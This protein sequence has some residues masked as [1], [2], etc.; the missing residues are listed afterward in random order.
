M[1][2]TKYKFA[3]ANTQYACYNVKDLKREKGRYFLFNW[4]MGKKKTAAQP[5]TGGKKICKAVHQYSS[6]KISRE[7]MDR[8]LDIAR[9]CM[10][11]CNYVYQKYGGIKSLDKIYPGYTVQNEMTTSSLREK[12]NLPTVYFYPAVFN[13]LREIKTQWA[14]VKRNIYT[15]INENARLTPED[16][17]YLR[18]VVKI[19]GC[20][21]NILNGK[22][23]PIPGEMLPK[24]ESIVS[25]LQG[26][27]SE[28]VKSLNRY[29]C[30]QVR[31]RLR[32]IHT[33]K[34]L[35][36]SIWEKG[37]RYGKSKNK[38]GRDCYGIFLTTKEHRKRIFIPLTDE[39][40]YSGVLD[41]KLKPEKSSVEMI[42]SVFTEVR[43]HKDY[44]N[45]IG[46]SLGL[47]DM[48]T[49]STG[50][51][52]GGEFGKIQKELYDYG[53]N[54]W[55]MYGRE[56][57]D[58][59]RK[60][61]SIRREKMEEA[62]KNYINRE[63]NRM[64]AE[65]K[66]EKI[67]MAKLPQNPGGEAKA[68]QYLLRVWKKGYVTERLEWKSRQNDIEMIEVLGKGLSVECSTCGAVCKMKAQSR[69]EGFKCENCGYEDDRKINAAKNALNRGKT[70]RQLNKVYPQNGQTTMSGR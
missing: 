30:R 48:I 41:I 45:E 54:E 56:N 32:K 13:A 31:K 66:P 69:Y 37:Y 16:K 15:A 51:V 34:F 28:C 55:R 18:F 29:L 33:D 6:G 5:Q 59:P 24:Y 9:D 2:K 50:H 1:I 57:G 62:L 52:Y 40:Q 27:Q 61:Y 63:I 20:F 49:T 70:G 23:V 42:A 21:A 7:D 39:N 43:K 25:G 14:H 58:A 47:W 3:I 10:T 60:K 38:E 65:E 12:L 11:V 22:P 17:H 19:D 8:L 67:Y 46:I 64:F 68:G 36:F 26:D 53:V 4:Q 44:T 35:Y